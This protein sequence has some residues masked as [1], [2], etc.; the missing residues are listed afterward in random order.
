LI[1][2]TDYRSQLLAEIKDG[3]AKECFATHLYENRE[4][5]GLNDHETMFAGDTPIPNSPAQEINFPL[6]KLCAY[7]V[8][9]AIEGGSDTTRATLNLLT[10]AMA[11]HPDF[12]ERARKELDAVCGDAGRLPTFEDQ[13]KLPLVTAVIKET[14]RWKPFVESGSPRHPAPWFHMNYFYVLCSL[15]QMLEFY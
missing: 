9:N 4:E 8:L 2:P 5:Y 3:T 13:A 11:T 1:S 12:V 7:S 14:L 10:A 15:S 6:R